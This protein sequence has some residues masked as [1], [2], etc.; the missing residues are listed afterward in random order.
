MRL[1]GTQSSRNAGSSLLIAIML[2]FPFLV[3]PSTSSDDISSGYARHRQRAHRRRHKQRLP[4]DE[5][6]ELLEMTA[7][8]EEEVA[9][10]RANKSATRRERNEELC[11]TERR[12][13]ELNS[14]QWEY[15]PPFIVEIKCKNQYEFDMGISSSL[16]DQRTLSSNLGCSHPDSVF[17]VSESCVHNLLRCVQRYTEVQTVRRPT[18]STQWQPYLLRSVPS[19]CECMWPVDK[20]GHQEL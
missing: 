5:L 8:S 11:A 10:P 13:R 4:V 20:Y 12:S 15:D 2:V 16:K 19:G 7:A 17:S 3:Q 9:H 14:H 6:A 1:F 18:H